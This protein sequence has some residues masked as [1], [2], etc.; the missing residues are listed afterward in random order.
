MTKLPDVVLYRAEL[1]DE[2]CRT[3][4][5][6]EHAPSQPYH[7]LA[8]SVRDQTRR[9]GRSPHGR[10]ISRTLLVKGLEFDHALILD[11][12]EFTPPRKSTWRSLG[13]GARSPFSCDK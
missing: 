1:Y 12:G 7:D 2:M 11:Y 13:P 9:Y 6:A 8:W 10:V 5:R 4:Q 3:L